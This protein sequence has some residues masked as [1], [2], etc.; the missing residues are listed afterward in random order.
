MK[1]AWEWLKKNW[2]YLVFPLWVASLILVWL[3][4]G[5]RRPIMPVSGTTDQVADDAA[6]AK[7]EAIQQFR[8]RLDQLA[9]LMEERLKNASKEQM[10]EFQQMKDKPIEEVAKWIDTVK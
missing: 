6:K 10:E 5:G 7:D 1:N 2:R 9:K 3:L 4:S 8:D